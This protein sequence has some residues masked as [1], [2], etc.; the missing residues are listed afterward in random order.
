MTIYKTTLFLLT[1]L[2]SLA[3]CPKALASS[4]P[5][6]PEQAHGPCVLQ[7]ADFNFSTTFKDDK[8]NAICEQVKKAGFPAADWPT[9]SQ[10]E[11]LKGLSSDVYYYGIGTPVDYLKAREAAF[12]EMG[13]PH[14]LDSLNFGGSQILMMI[15]ANGY[16]V[17]RNLDLATHIAC[18]TD[19][20]PAEMRGRLLQLQEMKTQ[21]S[22]GVFDL[23]DDITSGYEQGLCA[24]NANDIAQAKRDATLTLLTAD[25]TVT[26]KQA[27]KQLNSVAADYFSRRA[28]EETDLSGSA[29]A[30]EEI[31][32]K[33]EM[34]ASFVQAIEQFEQGN[35]PAYSSRDFKTSRETLMALYKKILRTK[36]T[37]AW[38]SV[39]TEDIQDAQKAW[40]GYSKA[41]VKFAEI[42]YPQVSATSWKTWL[43]NERIKQLQDFLG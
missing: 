1:A 5:I 22:P 12:L 34:Q 41:W 29:R 2:S 36:D 40:L 37:S 38:G 35:F 31:M 30:T 25:W 24:K 7:A 13:S 19:G 3:L 9:P 11:A 14:N 10:R 18:F 15:Y 28:A 4:C 16:G 8:L 23:C 33:D 26:Q 17:K 21:G 27:F 6:N 42:R 39:T 20:A 32:A 43:I